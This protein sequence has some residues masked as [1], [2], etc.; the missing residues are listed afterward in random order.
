[1]SGPRRFHCAPCK[2]GR[3][4]DCVRIVW[5]GEGC[6]HECY[7]GRQIPLFTLGELAAAAQRV[8]TDPLIGAP[9]VDW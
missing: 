8:E 5:D 9:P 6:V 2:K 7:N 3:C 1:M 4:E